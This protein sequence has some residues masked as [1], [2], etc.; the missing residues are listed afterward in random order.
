MT[1]GASDPSSI[2]DVPGI[3]AGHAAN[4]VARTGCTVVVM[5]EAGAVGGVDVRGGSPGTRETDVLGAFASLEVVH[6]FALCGGSAFGLDAAGGVMAEL[7]ARGRGFEVAGFRVPIVPAAVLFD[8][9]RGDG[10]VRPDRAMGALAVRRAFAS[11]AREAFA[12]GAVGVGTGASVA[13]LAGAACARPGGVGSA[14]ARY[15]DLVV[16]AV[17]A[18]NALGSVVDPRSGAIV[19]EPALPDGARF[20]DAALLAALARDPRE[21][22]A[23]AGTNTTLAVVV[24]NARLTK[25]EAG[26]LA[27]MAHDGLASAVRPAHLS[28]DGDT[29]FAAATGEVEA[30]LDLIAVLACETIARA[31]VRG[32]RAANA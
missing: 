6:A 32:V 22:A 13:K 21:R 23:P 1:M 19:A 20:S 16:G 15:G 3:V 26:A 14:S 25:L 24:T 30:P 29:I 18:C 31:I 9:T 27:R 28:G 17:A 10:R 12:D 4:D 8:L 11:D 7:E 2:F 5:P